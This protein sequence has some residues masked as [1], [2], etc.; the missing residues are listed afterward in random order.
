MECRFVNVDKILSLTDVGGKFQCHF[1]LPLDEL[2][3]L[4]KLF[5][6]RVLGVD[7]ADLVFVVVELDR[8]GGDLEAELL[9][10]LDTSLKKRKVAPL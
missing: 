4:S 5:L 6:V 1:L 3:L 2:L 7:V 8:V 10:K 9:L